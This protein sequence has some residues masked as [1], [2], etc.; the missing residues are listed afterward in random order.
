MTVKNDKN[1]MRS[2]TNLSAAFRGIKKNIEAKPGDLVKL[3]IEDVVSIKQVR[4]SFSDDTIAELAQS[5]KEQGLQ[6]PINVAKRSEDGKYVIIQG[7]RR[8][9]AC[10]SLGLKTIDAVIREMPSDEK[11]RALMQLVEN[12]QRE[13]MSAFELASAYFD[14]YKN[15]NMMQNEIALKVGKNKASINRYIT[16]HSMPSVI[17]DLVTELGTQD[18]IT[19]NRVALLAEKNE[20]RVTQALFELK[21]AQKGLSRNSLKDLEEFVASDRQHFI[22]EEKE[23]EIKSKVKKTPKTKTPKVSYAPPDAKPVQAKDYV[24]KVRFRDEQDKPITGYLVNT[25]KPDNSEM[26]CVTVKERTY[27]VPIFKTVLLGLCRLSELTEE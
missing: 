1:N 8:W 17:K 24:F 18:I 22:V 13:E 12:I 4:Q 21:D 9:R 11:E 7:E 19:I 15:H 23:S 20:R 2:L 14:L 3:P 26:I 27:T 10:K 25:W 5:I 6:Q 16:I